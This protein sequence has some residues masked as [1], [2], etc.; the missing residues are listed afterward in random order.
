ME[1]GGISPCTHT[2]KTCLTPTAQAAFG[3]IGGLSL[4]A[5]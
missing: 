3:G 4:R 1:R 5:T 2:G